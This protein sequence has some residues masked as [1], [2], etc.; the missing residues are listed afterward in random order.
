[1]AGLNAPRRLKACPTTPGHFPAIAL[2]LLAASLSVSAENIWPEKWR[3][4]VRQKA[5]PVVA[6]DA[7]LWAE[8]MGEAAERAIYNGPVGRFSA[9]A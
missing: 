3:D 9:T 1:M 6:A 5:T 4:N 8:Y 7:P 2:V